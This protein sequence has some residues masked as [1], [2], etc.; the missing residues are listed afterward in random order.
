MR[1][2]GDSDEGLMDEANDVAVV[3]LGHL[4]TSVMT[5]AGSWKRIK[6]KLLDKGK[7]NSGM[8]VFIG[9]MLCNS[10]THESTKCMV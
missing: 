6:V 3:I 5:L 8:N 7:S 1:V 9:N 10:S 2:R 4:L